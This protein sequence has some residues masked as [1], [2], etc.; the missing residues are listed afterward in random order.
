MTKES[1]QASIPVIKSVDTELKQATFLVLAPE[2]VD[3]HGDIYSAAEVRKACHNFNQWCNTANLLHLADTTSFNFVESYI[4]PSDMV[5]NET[6][7]K[8][9]SWLAV[10]QFHD[11][12]IWQGVKDGIYTGLS[13]SARAKAETLEDTV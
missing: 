6:F 2:Q 8:K 11:D 10:A 12:N 3:L 4:A 13:V 5:L 9:G 1:T 7:V